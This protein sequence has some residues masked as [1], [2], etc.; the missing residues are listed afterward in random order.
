MPAARGWPDGQSPIAAPGLKVNAFATGLDHTRWIEVLP[1]G[2]VLVGE[3]T[4]IDRPPRSVFDYA[5]VS[6]M[7]RADAMGGV[8]SA[9]SF[10][11]V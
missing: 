2:D 4:S 3:S 6:T 9:S 5:M 8:P 1:N 7:R 10:W 11:V